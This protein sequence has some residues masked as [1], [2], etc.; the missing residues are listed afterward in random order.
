[1]ITDENSITVKFT[2]IIMAVYGENQIMNWMKNRNHFLIIK[3]VDFCEKDV[4][5]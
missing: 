4:F 3:I 1:M 2:K 5:D